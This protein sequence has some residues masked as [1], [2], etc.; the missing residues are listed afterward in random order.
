MSE[1]TGRPRRDPAPSRLRYRLHRLWLTP[2]FR[3]LVR[4]GIPT[5]AIVLAAAAFWANEDNRFAVQSFIADMRRSVEERPEFMVY[6]M[7]IN[8]ASEPIAQDIREIVPVDFPSSSFDL[9]LE[10]MKDRIAELD[11]VAR[12]ELQVKSG[13]ILDVSIVERQPAAVWRV[14]EDLELLDAEGHRVAAIETRQDRADLPLLAGAG[15]QAAVPEALLLLAAAEPIG[16]RIR[17]IV[18][19]GERRWDIVLD[20]DQRIMLPEEGAM[21][22]LEQIIALHEAQD[23]LDRD[24]VAVDY[25]NPDRPTLRLGEGASGGVDGINFLSSGDSSQ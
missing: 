3:F 25:R 1:M 4:F 5:A 23:L 15:A 8:G 13:G 10:G 9:D 6:A 18:R 12:V 16:G 7:S 11:A 14:G 20:R 21:V 19:V 22:A 24:I 17:G 2:Y